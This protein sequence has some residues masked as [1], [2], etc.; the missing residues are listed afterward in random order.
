LYELTK[1]FSYFD[2]LIIF[3]AKIREL[4]Q[5][6]SKY[7]LIAFRPSRKSPRN[8]GNDPV[9]ARKQHPGFL[10]QSRLWLNCRCIFRTLAA[11][12]VDWLVPG[13]EVCCQVI[14]LFLSWSLTMSKISIPAKPFQPSL[15]FANKGRRLPW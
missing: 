4:S 6:G 10:F 9:T 1:I 5:I 12:R 7:T 2:Y 14:K 11:D 3:E 15:T 8:T 13:L